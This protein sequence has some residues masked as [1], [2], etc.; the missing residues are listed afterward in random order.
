MLERVENAQIKTLGLWLT[1]ILLF[2]GF[3]LREIQIPL[4]WMC[5]ALSGGGALILMF[6]LEDFKYFLKKSKKGSWKWLIICFFAIIVVLFFSKFFTLILRDSFHIPEST[7]PNSSTTVLSTHDRFGQLYFLGT[8]WFNIIG[9][10][11]WVAA[12][13]LPLHHFFAKK[14]SRN[15]AFFL[16]TLISIFFFGAMHLGVY[17]GDWLLCFLSIG[18]GRLPFNYAWKKTDSL[19]GGMIIHVLWDYIGF[20][21]EILSSFR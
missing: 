9:E 6:G 18:P 10:E 4:S 19:R 11:L 7:L 15:K 1:P 17:H 16:A 20:I 12:L 2:L 8:A 3:Y 5:H 21:T 13:T 14:M